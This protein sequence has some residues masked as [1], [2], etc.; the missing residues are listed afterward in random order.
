MGIFLNEC[1][2]LNDFRPT[3]NAIWNQEA[4]SGQSTRVLTTGAWKL[5]II[6]K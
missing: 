1:L 2:F 3:E 5:K 4:E 6:G